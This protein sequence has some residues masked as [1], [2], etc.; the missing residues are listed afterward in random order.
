MH[1]MMMNRPLRI[2]D[3]LTFAEDVHGSAGIVSAT[4]EGGIHSYSYR[5]AALRARK[6]AQA[7][8]RLGVTPEINAMATVVMLVSFTLV[9]LAQRV[10]KGAV[11][12]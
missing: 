7:L 9:L 5:E 2:A 3:I 6:L 8:L 4:V 10:N 12:V 1:G 11:G